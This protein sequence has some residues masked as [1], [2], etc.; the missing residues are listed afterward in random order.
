V[1]TFN[2]CGISIAKSCPSGTFNYSG[3][4]TNNGFGSL[5]NVTVTDTYPI[6]ASTNGTATYSLGRR[7]AVQ[8]R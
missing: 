3:S 4:V 2:V 8:F 1:H 6:D 7:S 5:S